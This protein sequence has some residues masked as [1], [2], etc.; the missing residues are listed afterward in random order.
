MFK[1]IFTKTTI[2][3]FLISIA[4]TTTGVHGYFNYEDFIDNEKLEIETNISNQEEK[5]VSSSTTI[6]PIL[7]YHKIGKMDIV[8]VSNKHK[9]YKAFNVQEDVF[10]EQ[11]KFI[12]EGGYTPLTIQDLIKDEQDKNLPLKPIAI[13]FDDG[14]RS[15]YD[16]ALPVL[17]KNNIPATFY[18]YTGVIG[19]N[20][21]MTWEDLHNLVNLKMEIGDHTKSHPH[22]TKI[23]TN[24]LNEELLDSKHVLEKNLHVNVTDFAYPYGNYNQSI[25]NELK[26]D[27]YVS[28]RTSNKGIYNDF[29]DM[30]QLNVLYAPSDLNTLKEMLNRS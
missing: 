2:E 27:G 30:Y 22:L 3:I 26:K 6:I 21:Y 18:I 5:V 15:Q 29:K 9:P 28:A 10:A 12:K 4:I 20:A 23:D 19:S 24:K 7:V 8:P 14:W 11:I 1:K 25:M 16:N 17:I 13:T